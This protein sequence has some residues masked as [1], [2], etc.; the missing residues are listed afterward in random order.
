MLYKH[1]IE[2][3]PLTNLHSGILQCPAVRMKYLDRIAPP[4]KTSSFKALIFSCCSKTCHGQ[5][6]GLTISPPT[7]LLTAFSLL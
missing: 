5:S 7:I 4:Q 3:Q 2:Q 1:E 6:P